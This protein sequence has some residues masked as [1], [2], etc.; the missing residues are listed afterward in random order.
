MRRIVQFFIE[1]PIWTN[2]S[3]ALV[4]MF[5]LWSVFNL[6]RSFFPELDPNRIVIS[7]F[8]PGASPDEMEEGVSIKVEQSIKGLKGIEHIDVTSQENSA[9]ITISAYQDT[10]MK[11][12]L[13]DVENAVNSIN[14]FPQG[15]EKPIITRLKTNSM[16]SNVAFVGITAKNPDK[17][18]KTDLTKMANKVERDLLNTRVITQIEKQGFPDNELVVNIRENDL[19]RFQLSMEEI[20]SAISLKNNDITA[21]VIRGENQE[22][23][24]RYNNR[25][26]VPSEI[27]N[28]IVRTSPTGEK[29][30]I[31]DVADVKLDYAEG[32]QE[33][34]FNGKP[35]ISLQI[36]K[37]AEED[38]AAISDAIKNY[39][40]EFN[41]KY[42]DYSFEIYFEFN[43]MLKERINLLSEN[44]VF[45]LALVLLALGLFL[46]VKLS[47][48]VAFGI[49]F[50]FL[51]M[52][53]LGM[54][55]GMTIN[56]ISL[57]GMIL[58]VGILV[59]DGIVIAENI[60][61][62]FEKG[63]TA[64]K[65][66]LD[67]TMEVL[68]S[69]F[70]SVL[71]TI[72]AF[73]V[74]LFVE[75]LE[76]MREMAFVVIACLSFSL[77]EAFFVLPSHLSSKKILSEN[78]DTRMNMVIGLIL[79]IVGIVVIYFGSRLITLEKGVMAT[80]FPFALMI[81]GAVIVYTGF[82]GSPIEQKVR[83]GAEWF[84]RKVRDVIFVDFLNLFTSDFKLFNWKFL[85]VRRIAVFI[86]LIFTITTISLLGSGKIGATFF[87][88]IPPDF[89]NIEVAYS[90]GDT[91]VKTRKFIDRATQILLEENKKIA[92]ATGDTML[93]YYTS[94]IG[95]TMNLGQ[96]G[97]HVGMVNVYYNSIDDIPV[98]TL[99]NRVIRR[100]NAEKEGKLANDFFVGGFNRFGADIEFGMSSENAVELNAA[101]KA[102][103]AE[104][105]G[106]EGVQNVK[107]NSPD[108]RREV[109]IKL[110]PQAEVFGL[111]KA[112][113][114]N[115]IRNG[116]FGRETQRVIIGT[117][118]VKIWVRYPEEDRNTVSDLKN[119][120]IK[121]VTGTAVPL[122]QVADFSID[123]GPESLKRRDG[124]R[125]VKVDATSLYPDSVAVFNTKISE[126][127]V[128]K[129]EAAF[130]GVNFTKMGQFERSQKTGNSMMYM[131]MIVLVA[132][133]I[134][135][136]LHFNSLFQAFMILL[137]IPAG[138]AG[139]ILG[140]GIV[141]IPVSVL[142]AF[143]MIALLGV[144]I[145]DAVV[146]LDKYNQ[147]ILEGKSSREAAYIAAI[148]RFR[149]I[150]LTTITTVAGLLPL[151]A[152]ESMQA[153]FLIPMA[154]SIA[155]GVLF[156]TLF[157]LAFFPSAI[158]YGNDIKR[159]FSYIWTGKYPKEE[160]VETVLHK[161]NEIQEKRS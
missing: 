139:A 41:E 20:A 34:S 121:T 129:I 105:S 67:G 30:R 160:E 14:S 148:A 90:P 9:Q 155:F 32:S 156:G 37:T 12:L 17:I 53:I 101:K 77:F 60:Y 126:E 112:E 59:D 7:V 3:I 100:I 55:Y 96:F 91:K 102:F 48:W 42:D 131:T 74:L 62:H 29:I 38:I 79:M 133:I 5:G 58:V 85:R 69:V 39:K 119:M 8:Y 35:S 97:N 115:Q 98:D 84:I 92:D 78:K 6:N 145:N 44:G 1:R 23:N 142:S 54:W 26:T 153:Q 68:P 21:G 40:K 117:D 82:S 66:A 120:R 93:S 56:M 15:A 87:P 27:E 154:V 138:I 125:Q 107:D 157:I 71:T 16:S 140:H 63:K 73:S 137:V 161:H 45:G 11:E 49:P 31:K 130:P 123:R 65:A 118:E 95:A 76:M 81:V 50:S 94:T 152:E 110:L 116:F 149:P 150:L 108:G 114:V 141:G 124:V 36:Q 89:F 80:L 122:Y 4:V 13:S 134:V 70:T 143:G 19:L 24:I 72:L 47:A 144:L 43:S 104:L 111:G 103:K 109:D 127:I 33:A 28:I 18:N 46:N 88:D 132:M 146:F 113:V 86:P 22:M 25:T 64:S 99:I 135:I 10:D 61:A 2:A 136:S 52:F 128:P 51:G 151:I 83:Q 106:M 75:G 57:F 147:T 159:I 158:L